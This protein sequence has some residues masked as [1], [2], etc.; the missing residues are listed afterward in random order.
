[1]MKLVTMTADNTIRALTKRVLSLDFKTISGENVTNATS[2]IWA[3]LQRLEMVG[4]MPPDMAFKLLEIFQSS[5]LEKLNKG[6]DTLDV[7]IKIGD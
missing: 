4:K 7:M 6:F 3:T 1:M 5:S 2:L